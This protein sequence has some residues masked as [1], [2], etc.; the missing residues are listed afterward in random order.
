MTIRDLIAAEKAKLEAA[1]PRELDVVLGGSL[2]KVA[3]SRLRGD[4]WMALTAEHP[5]RTGTVD[6]AVGYNQATLP[7]A[8]PAGRVTV[9]GETVDQDTWKELYGVLEPVHRVNI[10]NVM[11]GLNVYEAIKEFKALGKAGAGK[12]SRSPARKGSPRAAGTGGS[13]RK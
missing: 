2:V 12:P 11:W 3:V 1:A 4:E 9:D 5:P 8:Y 10:A 6:E 13:P 7:A